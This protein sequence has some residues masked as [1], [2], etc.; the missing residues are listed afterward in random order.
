MRVLFVCPFVPWPLDGGGKIRTFHLLRALG[1][2]ASIDLFL[3]REP[4][5][6][7]EALAA[8]APLVENVRIFERT[9]PGTVMR[10]S[11]AK[12]ERWFHSQA[13][14]KAIEEALAAPSGGYDAIHLDELLLARTLPP[15][16]GVP[17]VQ[18]H[19][20][21][22]TIL[23]DLLTVHQGPT[24][25]FDMWKLRQLER[26]AARRF[27]HHL[28]CSDG[29]RRILL[30]RYPDLDVAVVPSGFDD[31]H[32][33]PRPDAPPRAHDRIV[34]VGSMSYGPNVDA[35]QHFVREI[36]PRVRLRRPEATFAIVGRDP[37]PEVLALA[38]PG[39]EVVGGVPDVRPYLESASLMAV[40]LRIGGG[41][42]LKIPEAFGMRC[43]VVSTPI[44]AEGLGLEHGRELLLA[45][46][47]AAFAQAVVQLLERPEQAAALAEAGQRT[48]LE[49][50][51]WEALA[52]GVLEHWRQ[53]AGVTSG[54]SPPPS[55]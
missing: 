39:V 25:H 27:R 50:F 35:V 55:A 6:P 37:A 34:F 28:V 12:I 36:L 47:P 13:L 51:R 52:A 3:V 4:D 53:A 44:G 8:L 9:R 17:V 11:R 29:D 43:P 38:G 23:Y 19:H 26:D 2:M 10:W 33:R 24:R 54:G 20:K 31:N 18:H 42:R 49:R 48:A 45:R 16:T 15:G 22:D 32:F 40:P 5:T 7:P 30:D 14:R 41:T 21:I 46:Q 1:R